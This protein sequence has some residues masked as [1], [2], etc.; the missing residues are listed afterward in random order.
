MRLGLLAHHR[1]FRLLWTGETTSK[2]GSSISGI[3]LSL[4]AVST[5]H[6]STFVVAVLSA[7]AWLPW[8]LIGLPAG[9]WIDRWPR[10]PVMIACDLVS[11]CL[12]LSI[13][14]AAWLGVL[15]IVQ[16]L[17]VAVLVGVATVFFQTAYGAFLPSLLPPEDLQEGN[18][19]LQGSASAVQ[20]VGPGAGGLLAEVFGAVTGLVADAASFLVSAVCLLRI[21]TREEPAPVVHRRSLREEIGAGLRFVTRDPYLRVLMAFGATANLALTGYQAIVVVFLVRVV[22]VGSGA[23]GLLMAAT[24]LGGVAGALVSSRVARRF[25]TARA[26]LLCELCGP[27]FG[28]LIPLTGKGF[29]LI[30]FAVGGFLVV[31][32]V[33]ASNVI[34]SGFRQAYVPADLRGRVSTS[35]AFLNYGAI[36]IGAL[37]GGTLGT[38][39]GVRPTLWLMTGLLALSGLLLLAGPARHRRDYPTEPAAVR[40]LEPAAG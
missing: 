13:P 31:A 28:L 19:K 5:L 23:V 33:V 35:S 22:G 39:L 30:F 32:G 11:L 38:A 40:V 18:A 29:G 7:A 14:I 27:P 6:A 2:F 4:V 25:G 8:L 12:F 16:L 21:R 34:Q 10:R 36:P 17:L 3:A 1:D 26:V 24:S 9:A 20:V 15:S 37:L